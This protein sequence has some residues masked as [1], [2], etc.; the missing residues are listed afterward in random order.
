[1]NKRSSSHS[2]GKKFEI[3]IY[4]YFLEEINNG[5][6]L[7]TPEL[8][9][10]YRKKGYYSRDR[11]KEIIFDVSLEIFLPG[12]SNY[13]ILI[14]IECKDYNHSVPVDDVEEFFS[15]L[16][17]VSGANVKGVVASTN[18]FQSGVF[19]FSKS[20]GIG[21]L[22]YLENAEYKWVLN[23]SPSTMI[24][25]KYSQ[26]NWSEAWHCLSEETSMSKIFDAHCYSDG[27]YTNSIQYFLYNFILS[28]LPENLIDNLRTHLTP[29]EINQY[30][31]PF[32][33]K[34]TIESQC[35][36]LLHNIDYS[37]GIVSLEKIYKPIQEL[38]VSIRKCRPDNILGKITFRPI[39]IVIYTDPISRKRQ[40]FT[41][42]HE[43]GHYF[44][45][46]SEFMNGEYCEEED[47][48]FDD[49]PSIGIKDIIR[50]EWQSNY[51]AS[52]IL[53]PK[54]YF[55]E[56]FI[57]L[58]IKYDVKDRGYGFLFLDNQQ[59]N[60]STF[61]AISD[62]LKKYFDVS[63][64]AVKFRLKQLGLLNDDNTRKSKNCL[65]LTLKDHR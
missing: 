16:Q 4:N 56:E 38:A 28:N 65:D 47:F 45:N 2:S 5:R 26:D 7:T 61:M 60:I 50:M 11:Q 1:M 29:L 46:H 33:D 22:R 35:M 37:G 31:V 17:Q 12:Q 44:L 39:E 24:S 6:F 27:I 30:L 40:R 57:K 51:F 34:M 49:F 14:I 63:R 23:R 36:S 64:I 3:L 52:C 13:S 21:L 20:K 55:L 18:S 32:K 25:L 10:I 43:L 9:K 62:E 41:L 19:T 48:N 8:V 15:K 42:A 54:K 59:V 53:L 58:S